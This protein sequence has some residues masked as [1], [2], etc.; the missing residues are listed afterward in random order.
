MSEHNID[1]NTGVRIAH[2]SETVNA[3]REHVTEATRLPQRAPRTVE[4]TGLPTVFVGHLVL[5]STL[6]NGHS[7]FA[8]LVQRH[9]LPVTVL[10]DV[11][12]FLVREH[13]A[14]VTRR[15]AT[16]LDVDLQLTS[17]GRTVASEELARCSYCGPA[18]VPY[19]SYLDTVREHSVHRQRITFSDVRTAFGDMHIDAALLDAAA[20]SLNA[21]RPVM[22]HGPAGSGK[23][24]LAER[25]G[26]LLRGDVPIPYA[27]YVRGEIVQTYDPLLHHDA[28]PPAGSAIGDKRWR[29]CQ[30]PVVLSGGELT[31][32]GLDVRYD[33]VAGFYH[34]PPHMK[35]N[36]GLY[37]V[38]DLGRQRVAAHDLLNRW[39]M[40][41]DRGIDV[42]TLKSGVRFSSPFDVW[43]VFST[44]LDAATIG[45]EA[46][47]RRLGS[48][49]RVGPLSL[50]DYRS[51][52]ESACTSLGLTATPDAFDYLLHHLH[53]ASGR[54]FLACYPRDL[55][56]LVAASADYRASPR[57]V[58]SSALSEAWGSYFGAAVGAD[59]RHPPPDVSTQSGKRCA[60]G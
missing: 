60:S 6:L 2:L 16:D 8:D 44:N 23:T 4:D 30:R 33:A 41:L 17:A 54:P 39:I 48:K 32:E 56:E 9:C 34:A 52:F 57:E 3:T 20:A 25:L 26:R 31:L 18:P 5:K 46:F 45:D 21:G 38:D 51:V 47:L 11:L 24:F 1:R 53:R 58:T 13:L 49:L 22:L 59:I 55:L 12:A 50:V 19:E 27:L 14:V 43:P 7:S 40:P 29:I 35:A 37:V 28:S 36:M 15:G 10:E 42:F